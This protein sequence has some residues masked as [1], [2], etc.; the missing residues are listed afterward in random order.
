MEVIT[1]E[2]IANLDKLYYSIGEVA[3]MFNVNTSLIRYWEKEFPIIRPKKNQKGNRQF[4]QKD[5]ENIHK[6]HYLVKDRGMTLEGAKN[7]LKNKNGVSNFELVKTL[8]GI[9]A[10]VVELKE[11][12]DD[13][14]DDEKN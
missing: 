11:S 14:N 3:K 5:I 2:Q 7:Y 4:T 6:I 13:K 12:L 8:Q 10:M 9:R 1:S